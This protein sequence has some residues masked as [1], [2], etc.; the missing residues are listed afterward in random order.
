MA[1]PAQRSR[2]TLKQPG[3]GVQARLTHPKRT[4]GVAQLRGGDEG[5][6]EGAGE[7]Q[8]ERQELA[9]AEVLHLVS[10]GVGRGGCRWRRRRR[11]RVLEEHRGAGGQV[12]CWPR[13]RLVG[14]IDQ[15]GRVG[16]AGLACMR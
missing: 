13:L 15:F 9:A 2:L 14:P 16:G 6:R 3:E 8:E 5:G 4:G 11:R 7:E 10:G 12:N 1:S